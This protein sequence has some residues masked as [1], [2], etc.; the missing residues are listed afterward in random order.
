MKK[1][2]PDTETP[3]PAA[4]LV[5]I[6]GCTGL[7]GGYIAQKFLDEGYRV[8]GL[9]R[10]PRLLENTMPKDS[11][12]EWVEG[13][14]LDI[15]SLEKAM[16]AVDWVVHAAALVSFN[17][18]EK[19]RMYEVNVE[20]TANMVN[21]CLKKGITKLCHVS[22]VAALGRSANAINSILASPSPLI[23]PEIVI[24]EEVKWEESPYNT[25][26]A[27]SK[28]L[29]E[30]EVWRG[31]AEGLP[32]VVVNPSLVL[33]V[34][35][36]YRSSSRVFK[37]I[38]DEKPFYTDVV[39]NYVDARDVADIIFLLMRADISAK[40]YILSAGN[41]SYK[42][43]FYGIADAFQKKRPRIRVSAWLSKL[44][45]RLEWVRSQITR[46]APLITRETAQLAALSLRYDNE[47]IRRELRF[48]FRSINDTIQ[49]CCEN[50]QKQ[51]AM[52][53]SVGAQDIGNS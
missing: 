44:L 23:Q 5:L 25:H 36:W 29:A 1:T 30:L 6:T 4:S 15:P 33:G 2:P 32:A 38:W 13:D 53:S 3:F 18:G 45:W 20:G 50:Y 14:V 7:L 49:W 11:P 43:L 27:Q 31:V 26:Y 21:A 9:R 10:K 51:L 39:T 40:R 41:I 52:R 34:G 48:S 47:K 22:S 24:N 12:I 42:G 46:K 16:E 19:N 8:R 17:P 35:D 37:Y 28:Y